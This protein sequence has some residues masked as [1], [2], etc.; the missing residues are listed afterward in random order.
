MR[1]MMTPSEQLMNLHADLRIS[2]R[3]WFA[4]MCVFLDLTV[5]F[6]N[7]SPPILP[8]QAVTRRL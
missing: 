5:H 6:A 8:V 3:K 4:S 2:L 1:M 7:E